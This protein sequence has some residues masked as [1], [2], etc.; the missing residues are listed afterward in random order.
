MLTPNLETLTITVSE[1]KGFIR[2]D[3]QLQKNNNTLSLNG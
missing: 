1:L 2:M 3:R